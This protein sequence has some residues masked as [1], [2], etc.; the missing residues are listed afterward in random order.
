MFVEAHLPLPLPLSDA[1]AAL[2]RA[3]AE[4]GLVAQ[5]QKAHDE[6]LAYL[7][8]V[9]PRAGRGARKQ[10][11]V[12]LLPTR[13][14][15]QTT[16]VPMRWEATGATGRLFPS[17]DANLGLTAAGDLTTVLS[18]H[19]RYEPPLGAMGSTIDRTLLSGT[20][21]ATAE[22]LLR[23]VGDHLCEVA[24]NRTAVPG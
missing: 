14:V 15:G 20:A 11:L 4:G 5:S 18:V 21:N 13:V 1:Q 17:L 8:R 16:V 24:A 7:M 22:A 12:R 6:G 19:G 3:L 10:V 23:E 9:G 2:E